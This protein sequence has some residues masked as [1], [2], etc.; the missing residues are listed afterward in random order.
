MSSWTTFLMMLGSNYAKKFRAFSGKAFS[1]TGA[2]QSL[3]YVL[4]QLLKHHR[5][6]TVSLP[7]SETSSDNDSVPSNCFLTLPVEIQSPLKYDNVVLARMVGSQD[8]LSLVLVSSLMAD[9]DIILLMGTEDP[10]N[11][12]WETIDLCPLY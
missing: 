6:M 2:M 8:V 3:P 11:N 4:Q 5:T 9:H 12:P 7:T 10:K 1:M